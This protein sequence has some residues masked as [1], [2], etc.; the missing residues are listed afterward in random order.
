MR[1]QFLVKLHGLLPKL[2]THA[3]Y[4]AM[5][6]YHVE[7]C[8]ARLDLRNVVLW[9]KHKQKIFEKYTLR[10]WLIPG[11]LVYFQKIGVSKK[12]SSKMHENSQ[13]YSCGLIYTF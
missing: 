10:K 3:I 12:G 5:Q 6:S 13:N 11:L 7:C 4:W 2:R 1:M 8:L 9:N